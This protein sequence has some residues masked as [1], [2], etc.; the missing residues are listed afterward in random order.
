MSDPGSDN[1]KDETDVNWTAPE[2]RNSRIFRCKYIHETF[3]VYYLSAA[4][5]ALCI[6][7]MNN[8]VLEVT[9][10][11]NIHKFVYTVRNGV[12]NA[13]WFHP[14]ASTSVYRP[15]DRVL[16]V[17]KQVASARTRGFLEVEISH[18]RGK[19]HSILQSVYT[20]VTLGTKWDHAAIDNRQRVQL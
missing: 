6:P 12:A 10:A 13:T 5:A 19:F 1:E 16:Q 4:N 11:W 15:S 2:D 8:M 20:D 3:D 17:W 14:S 9:N 18:I 7:K